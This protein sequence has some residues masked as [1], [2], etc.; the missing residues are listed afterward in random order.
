MKKKT[1]YKLI[2]TAV[3]LIATVIFAILDNE[4]IFPSTLVG[5]FL[6]LTFIGTGDLD[7]TASGKAAKNAIIIFSV[8]VIVLNIVVTI[9][10]PIVSSS[11]DLSSYS[12]E[13]TT[14]IGTTDAKEIANHFVEVTINDMHE[15]CYSTSVL[16]LIDIVLLLI[17]RRKSLRKKNIKH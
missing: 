15:L 5:F 11:A 8:L 3:L 6:I 13:L 1:I 10:L 2:I 16:L 14:S 4:A 17:Y 7:K 12:V 9:F